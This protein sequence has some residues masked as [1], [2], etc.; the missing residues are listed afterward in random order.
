MLELRNNLQET[1]TMFNG[2]DDAENN[3]IMQKNKELQANQ[4]HVIQMMKSTYGDEKPIQ[5][6]LEKAKMHAKRSNTYLSKIDD[7]VQKWST[8]KPCTTPD[9]L[10]KNKEEEDEKET[11][12]C[13]ST[14]L[15]PGD[16]VT[17]TSETNTQT[18]EYAKHSFDRKVSTPE[19]RQIKG[20]ERAFVETFEDESNGKNGF[21]ERSHQDRDHGD[22]VQRITKQ[23]AS[24][25]TGKG[26]PFKAVLS[27][28]TSNITSVKTDKA[29]SNDKAE[30]CD[31]CKENALLICESC[32]IFCCEDCMETIHP[33]KGPYLK[34]KISSINSSGRSEHYERCRDHGLFAQLFCSY[35]ERNRCTE[36]VKTRCRL[37]FKGRIS[38]ADLENEKV[39]IHFLIMMI[40]LQTVLRNVLEIGQLL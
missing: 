29:V 12:E 27:C 20:S 8:I 26:G 15:V 35:C 6:T 37:H 36:C 17:K 32:S 14:N 19:D 24:F 25:S 5:F 7:M 30:K 40:I 13:V 28:N 23:K 39:I 18:T 22:S 38:D 1:N 11:N 2:K 9:H 4:E 21:L 16:E 3:K 10:L 34:H 31:F 33:N